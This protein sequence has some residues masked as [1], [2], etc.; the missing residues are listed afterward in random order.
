MIYLNK[1]GQFGRSKQS[2]RN[3]QHGITKASSVKIT[4]ADGTVTEQPAY[5]TVKEMR[6]GV[7]SRSPQDNK[8]Q[9]AAKRG[10]A[11]QSR[12][13]RWTACQQNTKEL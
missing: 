1:Y 9:L 3:L 13:R 10:L 7:Q 6:A 8:Q 5:R 12:R 2:K 4:H 11:Y